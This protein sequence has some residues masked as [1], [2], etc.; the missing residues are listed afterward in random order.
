MVGR[1][2][3]PNRWSAPPFSARPVTLDPGPLS[4]F[5]KIRVPTDW[6]AEEGPKRGG[7]SA[8]ISKW[9]PDF[10]T[11][12]FSK[13]LFRGPLFFILD[14]LFLDAM[15][16][17]SRS[18]YGYALDFGT[19]MGKCRC[20]FRPPFFRKPAFARCDFSGKHGEQHGGGVELK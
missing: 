3:D 19:L 16:S 1:K 12:F 15:V 20:F 8:A 2:T 18:F 13:I 7:G 5:F 9:R 4:S 14:A 6:R 10:E 17:C 11:C